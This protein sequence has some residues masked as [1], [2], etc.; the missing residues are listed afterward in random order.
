MKIV[1]L[2]DFKYAK[3]GIK[4]EFYKKNS[5]H[6]FSEETCQKLVNNGA[7]EYFKEVDI[8]D[9]NDALDIIKHK[10]Y[11]T[12][13]IDSDNSIGLT[14]EPIEDNVLDIVKLDETTEKKKGKKKSIL[15]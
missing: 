8:T 11:E 4:V 13:T 10:K 15:D 7:A 3:N 5:L 6:E 2:K 1:F 14:V 12:K 9:N